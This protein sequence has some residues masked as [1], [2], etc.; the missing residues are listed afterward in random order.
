M[1]EGLDNVDNAVRVLFSTEPG[2]RLM[3]PDYGC[4][5]RHLL[6]EPLDAP[7]TAYVRALV[8]RAL[9]LH[10]PRVRLLSVALRSVPEEGRVDLSIDYEVCATNSR[11]NMVFP[12]YLRENG[13]F[14]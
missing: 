3:R 9:L 2:E 1:T 6:F 10:E 7:A 4:E 11:R 14:L 8:E 13:G 12:Y 5:L